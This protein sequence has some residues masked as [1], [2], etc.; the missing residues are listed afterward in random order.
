MTSSNRDNVK[1]IGGTHLPDEPYSSG[2]S[3]S[4]LKKT[5]ESRRQAKVGKTAVSVPSGPEDQRVKKV[6]QAFSPK[7][8]E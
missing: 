4:G 8:M 3:A 2:A 7:K 5:M 6:R 1:N